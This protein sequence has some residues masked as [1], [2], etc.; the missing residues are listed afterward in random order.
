MPVWRLV[1][2][3]LVTF[4][5]G[6]QAQPVTGAGS[7]AAAPIY[8]SWA[9]A[10]AQATGTAVEYEAVGSSQGLERIRAGAV[11]FGASDVAL[12]P[13]ELQT[14]GL[15]TFP[16][17]VT[18][19]VPV[20]HLPGVETGRL[21]L[22]GEVLSQIFLGRITHWN[23]PA[24]AALNPGLALPEAPIGVVVRSDGSGTTYNLADYLSKV[25]PAWRTQ[26][27]RATR[28][29]WPAHFVG[30]KGSAAMARTVRDTP[31]AIGYVDYGYVQPHHLSSAQM[32]NAAGQFLAPSV[33][34]FRRALLQSSW[35]QDGSYAQTLTDL[36][37]PGVWPIT[38][39]T[40]VVLPQVSTQPARTL[41]ALEFFTW[42]FVN[43]DT[44]VQ[45][46]A[47]VRLPDQVQAVAFKVMT[48]VRGT[49]G[50]PLGL[51]ML[52]HG[53]TPQELAQR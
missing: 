6:V 24:I 13:K 39:G 37:G 46:S 3:W 43:G 9:Q 2:A 15:V 21:R 53:P 7:S 27:G 29:A 22:N 52:G 47:F 8:H 40:F 20:Y 28:L 26:Y 41:A 44:L 4:G 19:I 23:A 49:G 5:L 33:Q 11:S 38:M 42:A 12:T 32:Q 16:V 34:G 14:Q 10:Y 45:K 30:V 51:R 1:G 48:S 25:S 31:Y 35:M 18:G 36:P 50:A 17:A